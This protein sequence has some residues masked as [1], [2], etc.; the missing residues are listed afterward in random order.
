MTKATIL[1]ITLILISFSFGFAQSISEP[2]EIIE[3]GLFKKK[4][5]KKCD[6]EMT[7]AQ[8]VTLFRNDPNMQEYVKPVGLNYLASLTLKSAASILVLWPVVD[9]FDKNSD[10]NWNLAYIGAGCAVLSIPFQKWFEKNA[11]QAVDYYNSGYQESSNIQF[12]LQ[13]GRNGL[14]L[15]MNF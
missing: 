7:P 2:I 11:D 4:V 15:V 5:Y 10:P 3:K 12:N 9:S 6:I 13:V 1:S 14:G 8:L